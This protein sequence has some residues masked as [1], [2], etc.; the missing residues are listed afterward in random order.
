[1]PIY[2][3]ECTGCFYRFDDIRNVDDVPDEIAIDCPKC[4]RTCM[5]KRVKVTPFAHRWN[6]QT[7]AIMADG[8]RVKGHFGKEAKRIRRKK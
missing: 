1:M 3:Y 8:S 6:H 5:A 2:E 4:S 7:A